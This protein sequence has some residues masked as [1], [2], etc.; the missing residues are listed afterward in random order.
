L[1][2]LYV[3]NILS[4]MQYK[5]PQVIIFHYMDDI[6][7]CAKEKSVVQKALNSTLSALNSKH[8]HI[9]PEEIQW[10]AP[11]KYLGWKISE[12][13]ITPQQVTIKRSV[14]TLNDLQKLLGSINW[15]SLV[16]GITTNELHPLFSLLKGDPDL[17]SPWSHT[18]DAEKA[19]QAV[20]DKISERQSHR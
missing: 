8:F 5:F 10:D 12:S 18:V 9:A 7:I 6:L 1:C 17:S 11:W 15:L 14:H 2:Q 16:L 20:E 4:P 19:L 3:S 13:A